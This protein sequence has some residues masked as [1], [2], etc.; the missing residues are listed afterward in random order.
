MIL[1]RTSSRPGRF[2]RYISKALGN[3]SRLF[4]LFKFKM[5]PGLA[6]FIRP[7]GTCVFNTS[8]GGCIF[9]SSILIRQSVGYPSLFPIF[10]TNWIHHRQQH[11]SPVGIVG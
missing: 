1:Y 8:L 5:L 2:R 7:P 10:V 11:L 3:I 6:I 4:N 9:R